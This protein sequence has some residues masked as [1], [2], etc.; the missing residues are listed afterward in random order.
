MKFL[1]QNSAGTSG[2][3]TDDDTDDESS[4]VRSKF[5]SVNATNLSN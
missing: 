3:V 4:P 1:N 2:L 5:Q